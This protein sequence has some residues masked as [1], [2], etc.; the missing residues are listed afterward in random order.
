[1]ALFKTKLKDG[2]LAVVLN[3]SRLDFAHVRR[4]SGEMPE[5]TLLESFERGS[6][7]LDALKR[8]GAKLHWGQYHCTTLL[9]EGEY[10][11]L[12]T[13]PPPVSAEE[14]KDALRWKIKDM[15]DFPVEAA[16]IDVLP[17]PASGPGRTGQVFAVAGKNEVLA[18]RI[19]LFHEA[20]AELEAVD[21]PEVAQRNIAALFEE[22]NRGLVMLALDSAGSLLT[23]TYRGELY[24]VRHSDVTLEQLQRA[25]GERREQWF[26]KLALDVQRSMDNFDRLNSHITLKRLLISPVPGVDGF[27]DY[28]RQYVSI[29]VE[30]LDLAKVLAFPS[31]P[32]LRQPQRQAE[33]LRVLG[34]ALRE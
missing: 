6:N 23:F 25:E 22:E 24:V 11:M 13:D 31:I 5:V 18:S 28:L 21:I 10:Q 33:C 7:D 17:I 9:G 14:M 8:I 3:G 12:Q 4:K 34:A 29:P 32:E 2:W 20:K 15:V 30:E 27:I 1:M 16:T 19:N 26:E